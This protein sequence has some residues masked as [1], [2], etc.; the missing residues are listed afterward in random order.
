[1]E[2][3]KRN[4]E[5]V[6]ENI[7]EAADKSGRKRGDITLV[8]VT[9]TI[10]AERINS[11]VSLG[12]TNLGENRVQELTGKYELVNGCSWHLIGNLQKNKVKYVIDKVSL[13]QSVESL[14]LAQ[15]I[16]NEAYKRNTVAEILL[17]INIAGEATKHGINPHECLGFVRELERFGN[18]RL[19][20]LMTV[21]PFVENGEEN[22]DFFKKMFDLYVDISAKIVNNKHMLVLSMGMTGDYV[23]AIEEGANMVRVGTGIFGRREF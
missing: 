7:G 17:E 14:A 8:G 4:L 21:A 9:K 2:N 18:I 22:R 16:N 1:V 20:G 19:Q 13:I 6:N 15:Q 5:I 12:V 11:L 3:I 10:D 23:Q